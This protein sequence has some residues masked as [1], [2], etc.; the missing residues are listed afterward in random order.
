METLTWQEEY[1]SKANLTFAIDIAIIIIS[2]FGILGSLFTMAIV[3]KWTKISSGAAFMF[4]LAF[5]D[6]L[7][8]FYDGIIDELRPFF[9]F[10]LS[11]I[12][13]WAC[14]SSKVFSIAT[15]RASVFL[16][17]LFSLDKCLAVSFP[18]KYKV[19]G[20]KKAAIIASLILYAVVMLYTVQFLLT[21]D[22]H[23]RSG[24]CRRVDF[25]IISR[26]AMNGVLSDSALITNGAIPTFLV[27]IFSTV[28]IIK[29]GQISKKPRAAGNRSGGRRDTEI[30]RQMIVVG[31]VF[32]VF[33]LGSTICVYVRRQLPRETNLDDA[34]STLIRAFQSLFLAIINASN[35]FAYV[36]FGNNFRKDF[37][38]LFNS[39]P[40][41][42]TV[43]SASAARFN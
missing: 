39:S 13:T 6:L 4:I 37:L 27:F 25:S 15:S 42:K 38:N 30:T 12:N 14:K 10:V 32:S 20:T 35:F 18:F 7:A 5:T 34:K 11:D 19:Y 17:V 36:L 22:I 1:P 24:E 29:F 3:S 31:F 9:G 28:T 41:A 33:C 21:F 16:T 2:V 40:R 23:E 8:I 26:E 43:T